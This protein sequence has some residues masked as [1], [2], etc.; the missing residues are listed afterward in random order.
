MRILITIFLIAFIFGCS[1]DNHEVIEENIEPIEEHESKA[2]VFEPFIEISPS[3][4]VEDDPEQFFENLDK[5]CTGDCSGHT[6][7]FKWAEQKGIDDIDDC[8]GNSNSF[9][10]GCEAYVETL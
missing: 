5:P 2:V 8:G 1:N 7:G 6:A 3:D 9:I 10:E 4:Q